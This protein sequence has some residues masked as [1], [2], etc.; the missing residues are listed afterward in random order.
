MAILPQK[1][2]RTNSQAGGWADKLNGL[3]STKV[4]KQAKKK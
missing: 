1:S 2:L 3:S 4:K